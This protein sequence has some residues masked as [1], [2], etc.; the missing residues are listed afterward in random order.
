MKGVKEKIRSLWIVLLT[1]FWTNSVYAADIVDILDKARR[2]LFLAVKILGPS[3]GLVFVLT[4]IMKLR[5]KDEDPRAASQ[6][7]WYIMAGIGLGMA[8]A[9]FY[10]IIN[11]F[12]GQET[13]TGSYYEH[14][15]ESYTPQR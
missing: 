9:L 1:V 10:L 7:I 14:L 8:V 2:L 6:G 13:G 4:G 12:A 11:Y 3:L 5:R 15:S